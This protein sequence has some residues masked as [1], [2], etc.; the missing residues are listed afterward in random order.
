MYSNVFAVIISLFISFCA[1]SQVDGDQEVLSRR[2]PVRNAASEI[3]DISKID[4]LQPPLP[5]RFR[6]LHSMQYSVAE[7]FVTVNVRQICAFV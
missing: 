3:A 4:F 6:A 5:E 1:C 7:Q 2:Q